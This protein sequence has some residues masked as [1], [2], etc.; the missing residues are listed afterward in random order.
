MLTPLC[1][2]CGFR[3]WDSE[4]HKLSRCEVLA[5]APTEPKVTKRGFGSGKGRPKK[6][7]TEAIRRRARGRQALYTS[8]WKNRR[9]K[10]TQE[11]LFSE[12]SKAR[13]VAKNLTRVQE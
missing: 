10:I 2:V 8:R 4:A 11:T 5:E 1:G 9:R 6:Y 3:H 7:E 13:A 12:Y